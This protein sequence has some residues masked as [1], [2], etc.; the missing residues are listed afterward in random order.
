M[1]TPRIRIHSRGETISSLD[2]WFL[3]APPKRGE[4][5]WRDGRSAKE[6]AKRWLAGFPP[7]IRRSLDSHLD[8]RGFEAQTVEPE[9]ET[10]LDEFASP[11]NHD[12]VVEGTVDSRRA[13]VC[14][15]SKA[16]ES[17]DQ[18]VGDRL[19]RATPGSNLPERIRRISIGLLG[20]EEIER[21]RDIRYQLLQ[22]SA[23]TLIEAATRGSSMCLFLV[24]V[25]ESESTTSE[26]LQSNARDLD[27][28]VDLLTSGSISGVER[29]TVVGPIPV[30]GYRR[31]PRDV[32]FYVGK[33]VVDLSED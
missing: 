30:P 5:Q 11:R 29:N 32:D 31:I 27:A 16:D 22:A 18:P 21:L 19:R 9:F 6:T 23:A 12:I 24:H 28:F 2:E 1:N 25:F 4:Y 8:W 17:F 26:K 14:I 15:E 10:P 33:A 13:L 3:H 20:T 7:E